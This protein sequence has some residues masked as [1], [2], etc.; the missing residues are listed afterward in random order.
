MLNTYLKFGMC[1]CSENFM[2]MS[3]CH[4][5][6]SVIFVDFSKHFCWYLVIMSFYRIKLI[7]ALLL[8]F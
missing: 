6:A 1:N 3:K 8:N 2:V 7:N 4:T 5:C